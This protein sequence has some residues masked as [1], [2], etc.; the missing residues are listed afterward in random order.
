MR[1]EHNPPLFFSSTFFNQTVFDMWTLSLFQCQWFILS[2]WN[3]LF[4]LVRVR[5]DAKYENSRKTILENGSTWF[6]V[7]TFCYPKNIYIFHLQ[8]YAHSSPISSHSEKERRRVQLARCVHLSR[9]SGPLALF[10]SLVRPWSRLSTWGTHF[11]VFLS[12]AGGLWGAAGALLS[13]FRCSFW[14][15]LQ[16]GD[17]D[18]NRLLGSA[19]PASA[20][21][22]W[23][24][25]TLWV[26]K[27][28]HVF[29]SFK[30]SASF[31]QFCF[32]SVL[33]AA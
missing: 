26:W 2:F 30:L 28:P 12:A 23:W 21:G 19:D 25:G 17:T 7:L 14:L 18:R 13:L 8:A 9:R 31:C 20:V 15:K 4:V 33:P 24:L 11:S 3:N 29:L 1:D 10:S 32:H 6:F 22:F 16:T 5:R 27:F